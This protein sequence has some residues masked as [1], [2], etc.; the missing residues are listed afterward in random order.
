MDVN[1]GFFAVFSILWLVA[2]L[3]LLALGVWVA[4]KIA[5]LAWYGGSPQPPAPPVDPALQILRERYARGEID[6]AEFEE[7]RRKLGL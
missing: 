2:S 3:C 5:R 6:E 1:G 4:V 7:R